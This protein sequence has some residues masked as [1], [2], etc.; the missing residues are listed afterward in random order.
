MNWNIFS[1]V[2]RVPKRGKE[3]DSFHVFIN[4][5]E[6]FAPKKYLSQREIF[7][8]NYKM[9]ASCR[10][11][12]L[13]LLEVL[14]NHQCLK[15]EPGEHGRALFLQLKNFYDPKDTLSLKEALADKNL[16]RKFRDLF[17]FFY[18]REKLSLEEIEGWLK[19]LKMP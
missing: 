1:P 19:P 10:K 4:V 5:I 15:T 9:M 3:K 13:A 18:G 6:A 14:S 17:I 11:S 2:K 8:Y 16:N 7:Y 12:L